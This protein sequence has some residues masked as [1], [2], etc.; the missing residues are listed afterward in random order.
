MLTEYG[1]DAAPLAAALNQ[2][3][4]LTLRANTL[5]TTRDALLAR[6]DREG[7]AATAGAFAPHAITLASRIDVFG[8]SAYD[9]GLF[10]VQDEGSQL[11]AELV[12]PS[13]QSIVVD[14]CA[15]SGGKT[16]AL[17]AT[18]QGKGRLLALDV[19]SRKLQE[20]KKRARHAGLSSVQ[21]LHTAP[22]A[23]PRD[24]SA[25]VG[26]F[27]RVL[28]DAPCTGT[29]ALRRNP[30]IR[31]RLSEDDVTAFSAEQEHL[32][33]RAVPLLATGGQLIYATC[34]L[35]RA[36]NEAVVERLLAS[37]RELECV[38]LAAKLGDSL[39]ARLSD[40]SGRYLKTSPSQHGTDAFFAAVLRRKG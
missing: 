29:G 14:A 9:E 11:I 10:E 36:E 19:D 12:A 25:L 38:A 15:G 39:G 1:D 30:E 34:S 37:A 5:K 26:K 22:D 24:V 16:L 40:S 23:W 8:M 27:D 13:P 32:A 3:A 21:A 17:A 6:F 35:L 4:P 20:L 2:R 7:I 28:V 33:R 31:W 18:M